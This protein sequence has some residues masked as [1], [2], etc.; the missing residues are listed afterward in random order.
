MCINFVL[1]ADECFSATTACDDFSSQPA[2]GFTDCCAQS[3]FQSYKSSINMICIPCDAA[4]KV[5]G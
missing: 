2:I 1:V 5:W 3:S 4:G